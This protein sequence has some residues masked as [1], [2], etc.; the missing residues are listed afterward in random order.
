MSTV[1]EDRLTAALQARADLVQPEDLRHQ[2]PQPPTPTPIWRRPAVVGLVA[3]ACIV[4]V[5]VPL[6]SRHGHAEDQP[7][8]HVPLPVNKDVLP[9]GPFSAPVPKLT[10][11]LTG[12]VDGDGR[13]DEIRADRENLSVTLAADPTHPISEQ[14]SDLRGLAGLSPT[15]GPAQAIVVSTAALVNGDAWLVVALRHGKLVVL[16]QGETATLKGRGGLTAGRDVAQGYGT[17]WLTPGGVLMSGVL[18][19]MQHGQR[20]LAVYVTRT[21][22][23]TK[24]LLETRLGRWCW[25]VATQQVPA[26][27]AD[28]EDNAFDPGPQGGLPT[29]LPRFNTQRVMF[30]NNDTWENGTVSLH[31]EEAP[32]HAKEAFDQVYDLVGTIHGDP[33]R[34]PAGVFTPTLLKTFVDLGHGVHGLAVENARDGSGWNLLPYVDHSLVP[35]RVNSNLLP[36]DLYQTW[37]AGG[38]AFT[39]V[40]HGTVGHYELYRWEVTDA[41]GRQVVPV[42]LG[43]VCMDD[44]EDTY[45]NCQS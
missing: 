26:P 41:S 16:A 28:G 21:D 5:V 1:I 25:D 27:C 22:V 20:R 11:R 34:A 38:K 6:A 8:V 7:T 37:V 43:E 36:G 42:D 13:P 14:L 4:A 39:R 44:F 40:P 10:D 9:Q 19:P 31:M 18:N 23:G 12:D 2:S 45:G 35:T 3:A 29:L 33:V 17:S 30:T 24:H 15:R 32:V